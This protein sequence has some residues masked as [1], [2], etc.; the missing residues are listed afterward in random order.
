MLEKHLVILEQRLYHLIVS[1]EKNRCF[2]VEVKVSW[3]PNFCKVATFFICKALITDNWRA[4]GGD[5][6]IFQEFCTA[7][8]DCAMHF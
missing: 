7:R 3:F 1:F 5:S 6:E 4:T 8:I 2:Q